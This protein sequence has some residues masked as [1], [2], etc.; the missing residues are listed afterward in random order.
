MLED[1][2]T[3]GLDYDMTLMAWWQR[4][5]VAWPRL[6][7]KYG[8]PFHRMWRYYLL[9]AAGAFRARINHLWQI[10]FSRPGTAAPYRPER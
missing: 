9:S 8:E 2:H 6:A 10:V 1:W 4:F 7:P 3:F 5:E